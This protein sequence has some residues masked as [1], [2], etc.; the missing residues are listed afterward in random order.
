MPGSVAN[1]VIPIVSGNP[2]VFPFALCRAFTES[3]AFAARV[4][5]YHDG[6]TQRAAVVTTSRKSWKLT[7]RLTPAQMATLRTF[8]LTYPT[9]AFYFYDLKQP[10]TGQLEGANYDPTG[11]AL[12]GRY[13]VRLNGDLIETIYIART[14]IGVE[15][16]EI[17]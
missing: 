5:E 16:V 15:L 7:E 6:T 11:A 2:L 9:T 14:E 1:C 12:P 4:N 8:L 17:A 3:S 10:T 13:S